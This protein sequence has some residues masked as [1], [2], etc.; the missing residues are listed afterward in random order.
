MMAI[1][2]L[3][4]RRTLNLRLAACRVKLQ[5]G[6]RFTSVGAGQN[7]RAGIGRLQSFAVAPF[8]AIGRDTRFPSAY[9]DGRQLSPP[10]G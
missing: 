3:F 1:I 4:R 5:T 9:A 10:C 2:G 7:E 8:G 6:S